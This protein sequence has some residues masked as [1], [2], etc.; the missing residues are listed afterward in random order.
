MRGAA[1][2][3][4]LTVNEGRCHLD[5]H[6]LIYLLLAAS[7]FEAAVHSLFE[8]DYHAACRETLVAVLYASIVLFV[9]DPAMLVGMQSA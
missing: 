3:A 6:S 9:F 2:P 1:Q 4:A 8:G 5:Y 7:Y